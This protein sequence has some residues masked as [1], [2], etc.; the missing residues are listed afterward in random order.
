MPVTMNDAELTEAMLPALQRAAYGNA[1]EIE[2]N[3]A[4]SEDFSYFAEK[5]PGLYVFL[6]VTPEDQDLSKAASNHHP[7]FLIDEAA[8]VTG[9][10][11]HVEFVL[12]YGNWKIGQ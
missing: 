4:A 8:L 9:V 12:E 7:A 10:R 6:G 5:V 3:Q 2:K 11:S 1:Q